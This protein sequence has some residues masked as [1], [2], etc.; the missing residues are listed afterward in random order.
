MI[1]VFYSKVILN[2][3]YLKFLFFVISKDTLHI[4]FQYMPES[5]A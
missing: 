5:C 3:N 1:V 4:R 2:S